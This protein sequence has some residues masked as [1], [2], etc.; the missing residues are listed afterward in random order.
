MPFLTTSIQM[1]DYFI[2]IECIFF[3]SAQTFLKNACISYGYFYWSSLEGE[4]S[5]G[6]FQ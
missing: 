2:L 5:Q 1:G 6:D 3:K 4:K